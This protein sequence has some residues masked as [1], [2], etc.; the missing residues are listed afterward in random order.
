MS[1]NRTSLALYRWTLREFRKLPV[2]C[3]DYY[4]K[5]AR[6]VSVLVGCGL[7]CAAPSGHF[8]LQYFVG[9]STEPDEEQIKQLQRD[10]VERVKWLVQKVRNDCGR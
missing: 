8:C 10:G 1:H 7:A 4:L 6:S 2:N 3:R 9:H 5:L